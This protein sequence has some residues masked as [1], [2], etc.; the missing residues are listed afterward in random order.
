M[1]KNSRKDRRKD[2]GITDPEKCGATYL[3]VIDYTRGRAHDVNFLIYEVSQ[4]DGNRRAFQ[5]VPRHER[6]RAASH[7]THRIPARLRTKAEREIENSQPHAPEKKSNRWH[8]RRTS[9][10]FSNRNGPK[11][12]DTH[13]W[14]AKRFFIE[15][16][17][18][19]KIPMES[20][21]KSRRSIV[22]SGSN[23]ATISDFSYYSVYQIYS[24]NFVSWEDCYSKLIQLVSKFLDENLVSSVDQ[25]YGAKF[26][27]SPFYIPF[28]NLKLFLGPI[29]YFFVPSI[30]SFFILIH[31]SIITSF[32]KISNQNFI[33]YFSS[34]ISDL[35]LSAF[36][37][38]DLSH[39]VGVLV[40][41]GSKSSILLSRSFPVNSGPGKS[42]F[43]MIGDVS[44]PV[45]PRNTGFSISIFDPRL[46][47]LQKSLDETS[48]S[49]IKSFNHTPTFDPF[50]TRPFTSMS[51]LSNS[52]VTPPP[53]RPH[54]VMSMRPWSGDHV[55]SS[56]SPTKELNQKVANWDWDGSLIDFGE[57]INFDCQPEST[58]SINQRR[59]QS[60][61]YGSILSTNSDHPG[62]F[63]TLFQLNSSDFYGIGS[64]F[65]CL[66]PRQWTSIL[67][68]SAIFHGAKPLG[69]VD[70]YV[71]TSEA[72]ERW[73]PLDYPESFSGTEYRYN[74]ARRD[75]TEF[76]ARPVGK[77]VNHIKSWKN[78]FWNWSPFC[79]LI[80]S[81]YLDSIKSL[82]NSDW[83]SFIIRSLVDSQFEKERLV[84]FLTNHLSAFPNHLSII[85]WIKFD[86]SMISDP[87]STDLPTSPPPFSVSFAP[88]PTSY[89]PVTVNSMGEG[90]ISNNAVIYAIP[91]NSNPLIERITEKCPS[92]SEFYY[93]NLPSLEIIGFVT[94]GIQSLVRGQSFSIG[95][96]ES[97]WILTRLA[98]KNSVMALIR[99]SNT[100][101]YRPVQL[102]VLNI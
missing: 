44:G 4:V 33:D 74:I 40:T 59:A 60:G 89:T 42:I 102:T 6:R 79:L 48:S 52:T 69:L 68:Q 36:S 61:V 8:R 14:H 45:L 49:S 92:E 96:V 15:S 20:T 53:T 24:N 91:L 93:K 95:L 43:E 70:D 39:R 41:K 66:V 26:G 7:D 75:Y 3:N 99:Q 54:T 18:G 38:V 78:L 28:N 76:R 72:G 97:C 35:S 46:Y 100:D 23:I 73:F 1:I 77:R 17:W 51:F 32:L 16:L 12:L 19:W 13:V 90:T 58:S 71:L 5:S 29:I 87:L 98:Q 63:M 30:F 84:E 101:I 94:S 86:C 10:D 47:P 22:K 83:M 85:D 25:K 27:R 64:G 82:E 9:L 62:P 67:F 56:K 11:W 21:Q 31:P 37:V 88:H 65:L 57:T 55:I 81:K 80:Y 50:S 34:I 2:F